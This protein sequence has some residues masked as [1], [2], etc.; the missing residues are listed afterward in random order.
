MSLTK[1]KDQK[2]HQKDDFE[3][4]VAAVEAQL[5]PTFYKYRNIAEIML[6]HNQLPQVPKEFK[7]DLKYRRDELALRIEYCRAKG[8]PEIFAND[9]QNISGRLSIG[10][11]TAASLF[12][13]AYPHAQ[14]KLI[15]STDMIHEMLCRTSP[16]E[17]WIPM[18]FTITDAQNLHLLDKKNVHWDGFSGKQKMLAKCNF[19]N[20]FNVMDR[21]V[22]NGMSIEEEGLSPDIVLPTIPLIHN[23]VEVL[24][25][26]PEI[27]HSN[28]PIPPQAEPV[29][30]IME[31]VDD[32][33]KTKELEA[34]TQIIN[35]SKPTAEEIQ[36]IRDQKISELP[37]TMDNAPEMDM[38]YD[39]V[40]ELIDK[41]F[42]SEEGKVIGDY[43][44]KSICMKCNKN[45]PNCNGGTGNCYECDF[46]LCPQDFKADGTPLTL[47][48]LK[49][50][51]EAEE[52]ERLKKMSKTKQP[53]KSIKDITEK[54][55]NTLPEIPIQKELVKPWPLS[56]ALTINDE[57]LH[58]A[59]NYTKIGEDWFA[60]ITLNESKELVITDQNIVGF[61]LAI[62]TIC[63]EKLSGIQAHYQKLIKDPLNGK[64]RLALLYHDAC[65]MID[66][67]PAMNLL[68]LAYFK[69]MLNMVKG[70]EKMAEVMKG[71]QV[72][73]DDRL[74]FMLKASNGKWTPKDCAWGLRYM[75]AR[76][77][78]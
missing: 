11:D 68:D 57:S 69:L 32:L 12:K 4:R 58:T 74:D 39:F 70:V 40:D 60:S 24:V 62:N 72:K 14:F 65:T 15:Q 25:E 45:K 59:E 28:I 73:E 6:Q 10:V 8:F 38:D 47:E 35:F 78:I 67:P 17:A 76:G 29:M 77:L 61:E 66:N 49:A 50:R 55:S 26:N 37:P 42:E 53:K 51:S 19:R 3:E 9:L 54:P 31:I 71:T 30:E 1:L 52:Q 46:K 13:Q 41:R 22:C 56:G 18:K 64:D 43:N 44:Y 16:S 36:E 33:P 27:I 75:L 34:K 21:T 2:E 7:D 63:P 5:E 20:S 48:E 23:A